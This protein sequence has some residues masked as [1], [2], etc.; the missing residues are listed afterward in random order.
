[1][2]SEIS[3]YGDVPWCPAWTALIYC[4]GGLLPAAAAAAGEI[5]ISG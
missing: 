2:K 4:G 5:F 1:M 3:A